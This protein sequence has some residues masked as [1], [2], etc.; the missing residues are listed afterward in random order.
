MEL[1]KTGCSK[2]ALVWTCECGSPMFSQRHA[3][4]AR[5]DTCKKCGKTTH[6]PIKYLTQLLEVERQPAELA[7][8]YYRMTVTRFFKFAR[9]IFGKN[10]NSYALPVSIIVSAIILAATVGINCSEPPEDVLYE[11]YGLTHRLEDEHEFAT[12]V[13]ANY[14]KLKLKH[15]KESDIEVALGHGMLDFEYVKPVYD[16][17]IQLVKFR[18]YVKNGPVTYVEVRAGLDDCSIL[19]Y[20]VFNEHTKETHDKKSEEWLEQSHERAVREHLGI[21]KEEFWASPDLNKRLHQH[22]TK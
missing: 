5:E 7:C 9:H 3:I 20:S 11:Q 16:G 8:K 14:K 12:K 15:L 6:I 4:V 18:L 19:Q 21:P 13:V 22:E 10:R 1:H 2:W 17:S